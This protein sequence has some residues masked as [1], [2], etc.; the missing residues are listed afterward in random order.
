[1]L[2]AGAQPTA[3]CCSY[4]GRRCSSEYPHKGF[5]GNVHVDLI[6]ALHPRH[7][8]IKLRHVELDTLV[9][10]GAPTAAC[11][12][13]FSFEL[14]AIEQQGIVVTFALLAAFDPSEEP[15]VALLVSIHI[16]YYACKQRRMRGGELS[17]TSSIAERV[18]LILC[19]MHASRRHARGRDRT[20]PT[21]LTRS[22]L[23]H[24]HGRHLR[25]SRAAVGRSG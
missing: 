11:S 17:S 7:P 3:R 20:P 22:E 18:S 25:L 6:C 5:Q 2:V 15:L 1:M 16:R 19:A 24:H 12:L 13:S 10:R 9:H 8:R 4:G 14:R 21:A 23:T